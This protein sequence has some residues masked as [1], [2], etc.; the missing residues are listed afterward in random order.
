ME[1]DKFLHYH[2]TGVKNRRHICSSEKWN[3]LILSSRQQKKTKDRTQ[4]M[5]IL[6]MGSAF[7]FL[8]SFL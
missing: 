7:L 1:N 2:G 3:E 8:E 5:L 6:K 4:C